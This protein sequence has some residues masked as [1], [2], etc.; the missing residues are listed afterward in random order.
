M[1]STLQKTSLYSQSAE[2]AVV[3]A[4]AWLRRVF[5]EQWNRRR[6]NATIS[7]LSEKQLRDIG[8]IA[9]D[10]HALKGLP[11]EASSIE[12]IAAAQKA[13]HGKW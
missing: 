8:L 3:S 5:K 11:L 12:R 1:V 9:S 2:G 4:F 7:S 6:L 10:L 13:R